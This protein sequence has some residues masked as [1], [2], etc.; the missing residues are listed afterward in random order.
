MSNSGAKRLIGM[1][2]IS[3][4]NPIHLEKRTKSKEFIVYNESLFLGFHFQAKNVVKTIK[5][6]AKTK[7]M[8][9]T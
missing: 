4:S 2:A 6:K 8:R 5:S 9:I 7:R 1:F 3:T